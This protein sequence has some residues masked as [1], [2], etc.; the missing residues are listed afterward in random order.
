MKLDWISD[1]LCAV[2]FQEHFT[3]GAALLDSQLKLQ[4]DLALAAE[5][6]SSCLDLSS[7]L[8]QTCT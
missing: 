4:V 3:I 6:D 7:A 2:V 8:S 5:T 1:T